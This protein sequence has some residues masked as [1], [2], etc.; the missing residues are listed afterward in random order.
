MK[1]KIPTDAFD[2]YVAQ[3]TGRSYQATADHFEVSKCAISKKAKKE[4]W[5]GRLAKIEGVARE[6]S[7]KKL[8]DTMGEMHDRHL[9]LLKAAGMRVAECLRNLP[10]DSGMDAIRGV[11]LIIK[12]ERL[13]AGEVSKRT[14]LSIEEITKREIHTLLTIVRDEPEPEPQ[15]VEA[16][17]SG[18]ENDDEAG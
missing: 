8:A 12:L 10:L 7:D 1:S 11:D 6:S 14:S 15:L 17:V 16:M 18:G 2:H 9:A 4:D 3:G 5:A 13:L